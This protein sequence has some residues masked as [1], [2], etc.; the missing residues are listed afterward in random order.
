MI[1]PDIW[2]I[3]E[4]FVATA[5]RYG[6]AILPEV[7]DHP[8]FQYQISNTGALVYGFA[9]PPLVLH[10]LIN[11]DSHYL[12]VWLRMCPH[13]QITVLDTHDGICIPDV[14]DILPKRA[15]DA[16]TENVS[17]WSADPILRRSAANVHRVG[18]IYQL[19]CTF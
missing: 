5:A 17:T 11:G 18:A 10:S 1:E 4:W 8:S 14:E 6:A 9:L 7:H 3:L 13:N 12:K 16:L 15:V 2:E 19:T